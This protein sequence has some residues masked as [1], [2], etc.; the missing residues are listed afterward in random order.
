MLTMLQTCHHGREEKKAESSFPSELPGGIFFPKRS[1]IQE[2]VGK[3]NAR[4]VDEL[5]TQQTFLGGIRMFQTPQFGVSVCL[6][7]EVSAVHTS[8]LICSFNP[9]NS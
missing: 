7:Y 5:V 4:H 3:L 8:L 9:A 2:S 1:T 6:E